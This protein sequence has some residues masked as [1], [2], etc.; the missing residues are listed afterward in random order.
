[1]T[2]TST[3]PSCSPWRPKKPSAPT[4]YALTQEPHTTSHRTSNLSSPTTPFSATQSQLNL[5]TIASY[6]PRAVDP[7]VPQ[8][9]AGSVAQIQFTDVLYVPL[10]TGNL[11]SVTQLT[12]IPGVSLAFEGSKCVILQ[13]QEIICEGSQYG[14]LYILDLAHSTH[15]SVLKARTRPPK[16]NGKCLDILTWHQR[17]GH[18]NLRDL[19]TLAASGMVNGLEM[20]ITGIDFTCEACILGKSTRKAFPD[21]RTH[22][23]NAPFRT[24]P[25]RRMWSYAHLSWGP[26]ILHYIHR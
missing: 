14:G 2:S 4:N 21:G 8:S 11:I 10:L 3:S 12:R 5:V 9:L 24:S 6:T 19:K 26:Q 7:S 15:A 16:A 18:L 1:M 23:G 25:F 13:D 17:L 22:E 20:G